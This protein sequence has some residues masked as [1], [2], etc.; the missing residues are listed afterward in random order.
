MLKTFLGRD[1]SQATF[2]NFFDLSHLPL[3]IFLLAVLLLVFLIFNF[4]NIKEDEILKFLILFFIIQSLFVI[5][6]GKDNQVQGRFALISGILLLF[7]TY[8]LSQITIGITKIIF[9]ILLFFSLTTGFYEYKINNKYKH[10]LECI[11]C[12]IWKDEVRN[13]KMDNN[14]ELKIWNYPGKTMKLN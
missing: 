11:N 12:P 5:Y 13:W 6:A 3:I 10:F 9:T 7:T 14:Y 4:K 2:H 1:L 8:R